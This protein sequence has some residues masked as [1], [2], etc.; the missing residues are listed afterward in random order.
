MLTDVDSGNI[1]GAVSACA[2]APEASVCV[3]DPR[4]CAWV[5]AAFALAD[6]HDPGTLAAFEALIHEAV[7]EKAAPAEIAFLIAARIE[8]QVRSRRTHLGIS[9]WIDRPDMQG[10]PVYFVEEHSLPFFSAMSYLLGHL[11]AKLYFDPTNSQLD[12]IAEAMQALC[13]RCD[14]EKLNVREADAVLAA[15]TYL[16]AYSDLKRRA[17]VFSMAQSLGDRVCERANPPTLRVG[18]WLTELALFAAFR[19]SADPSR[20]PELVVAL[21]RAQSWVDANNLRTLKF[22]CARVRFELLSLDSKHADAAATLAQS[23]AL[24]EPDHALDWLQYFYKCADSALKQFDGHRSLIASESAVRLCDQ[25]GITN[26]RRALYESLRACALAQLGR[27]DEA[28]VAYEKILKV[29]AAAHHAFY[30]SASNALHAYQLLA[31]DPNAAT[32]LVAQAFTVQAKNGNARFLWHVP[33][34][35]A[36]LQARA[37]DIPELRDYACRAIATQSL[38][39]PQDASAAW[40]WALRIRMFGRVQIERDGENLA[41][42]GKSQRKPLALLAFLALSPKRE[43]AVD[44]VLSRLFPSSEYEDPKNALDVA[45]FRLRKLIGSDGIVRFQSGV[46]SL[47]RERVWIDVAQFDTLA[48]DAIAEARHEPLTDASLHRIV[49]ALTLAHSVML[50]DDSLDFAKAKRAQIQRRVAQLIDIAATFEE[51]RQRFDAA[52][53]WWERAIERSAT[54]EAAYRGLMRCHAALGNGANALLIFRRCAE[55][56]SAMLG[57]PP[58]AATDALRQQIFESSSGKKLTQTV[59]LAA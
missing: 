20:L 35:S 14:P 16:L 46:L 9:T 34:I 45:L 24:I 49:T 37:V 44:A 4:T 21:E 59:R 54:D 5:D 26:T 25:H 33:K 57:V 6:R 42:D 41:V 15:C 39:P 23:E 12:A 56:T 55:V 36:A 43:A 8:S 30:E 2:R 17:E 47:D 18:E 38:T 19:A 1:S 22:K 53:D 10:N 32:Q 31:L 52:I 51:S 3:P 50:C 28:L 11:S 13:L 48:D 29:A 40:P 27:I 58:S 7:S